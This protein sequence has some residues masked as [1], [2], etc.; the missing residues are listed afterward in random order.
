MSPTEQAR[1]D[2][3]KEPKLPLRQSGEKTLGE[4]RLSQ[5]ASSPLAQ[6]LLFIYCLLIVL[7]KTLNVLYF[8]FNIIAISNNNIIM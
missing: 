2:S 5:G 3:G 8:H 7:I 1:G 6:I 4:T